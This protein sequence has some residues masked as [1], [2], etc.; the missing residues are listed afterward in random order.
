MCPLHEYVGEGVGGFYE[1][2]LPIRLPGER[3]LSPLF[4][5]S[6]AG[7][8]HSPSPRQGQPPSETGQLSTA[9]RVSKILRNFI[10]FTFKKIY[11][12]DKYTNQNY[13]RFS[14]GKLKMH[15]R[16]ASR[17][18]VSTNFGNFYI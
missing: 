5:L 9:Q 6:P 8:H 4:L 14:Y 3:P 16:K 13:N 1:P 18:M 15:A 2:R 10:F 12:E 7:F 11:F 17:F